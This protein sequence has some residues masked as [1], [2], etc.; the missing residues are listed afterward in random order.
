LTA[1]RPSDAIKVTRPSEDRVMTEKAVLDYDDCAL[2]MWQDGMNVKKPNSV[3]CIVQRRINN[4]DTQSGKNVLPDWTAQPADGFLNSL[5]PKGIR[6]ARWMGEPATLPETPQFPF[7]AFKFGERLG[8]AVLCWYAGPV[9][10]EL[11]IG[12]I[13]CGEAG[14][15]L[16]RFAPSRA[17]QRRNIPV[18]RRHSFG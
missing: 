4:S 17:R 2:A 6:E 11:M 14:G 1:K 12:E 9:R 15:D 10:S 8:A 18:D 3:R 13:L 16:G 7:T 5:P